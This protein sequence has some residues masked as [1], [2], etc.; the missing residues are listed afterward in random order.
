MKRTL[1]LWG[2]LL[3]LAAVAG[4]STVKPWANPAVIAAA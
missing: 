4:C 1:R 2:A 3:L